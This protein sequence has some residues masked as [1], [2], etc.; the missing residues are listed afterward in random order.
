MLRQRVR[1]IAPDIEHYNQDRG[2][3]RAGRRAQADE[4]RT[5]YLA[6][7]ARADRASTERDTACRSRR[8]SF[9]APSEG[10][11]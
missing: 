10:A 11:G 6:S 2:P 9:P 1:G 5:T 8:A 7:V 3:R 4:T